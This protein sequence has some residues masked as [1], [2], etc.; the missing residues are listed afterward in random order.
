MSQPKCSLGVSQSRVTRSRSI[1]K[2]VYKAKE[3]RER[4]RG[5]GWKMVGRSLKG[6]WIMLIRF[7]RDGSMIS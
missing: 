5:D 4:P 2:N 1:L 6:V 7:M 3:R